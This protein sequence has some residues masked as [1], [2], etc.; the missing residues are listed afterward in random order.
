MARRLLSAPLLD[1]FLR[2]LRSFAVDLLLVDRA[3]D[4]AEEDIIVRCALSIYRIHNWLR[5]SF[6]ICR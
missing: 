3:V 5:E 2:R 4:M 1:E 6:L